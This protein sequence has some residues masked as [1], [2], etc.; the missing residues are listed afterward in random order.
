MI[1]ADIIISQDWFSVWTVSVFLAGFVL[2][3][4]IVWQRS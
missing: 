2:G 4:A 1:A 3:A